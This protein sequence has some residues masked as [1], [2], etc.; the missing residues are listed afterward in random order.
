MS[1]DGCVC[2]CLCLLTGMEAIGPV[3]LRFTVCR[4]S[5]SDSDRT[6]DALLTTQEALVSTLLS[7]S[8]THSF[9]IA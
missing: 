8:V 1:V 5:N 7:E 3:A 9:E 2:V 6:V 4:P